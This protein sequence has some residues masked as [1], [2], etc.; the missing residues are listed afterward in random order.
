MTDEA[1]VFTDTARERKQMAIGSKHK[2]SGRVSHKVGLSQDHMSEAE[3]KKKNGEVKAYNMFVPWTWEEFKSAP[4]DICQ[5]YLDR[6]YECYHP[7]IAALSK[8][9]G[10][11]RETIRNQMRAKGVTLMC[12][13][14]HMYMDNAEAFEEFLSRVPVTE[15]YVPCKQPSKPALAPVEQKHDDAPDALASCADA[16]RKAFGLNDE[17]T[18]KE[19]PAIPSMK[20]CTFLFEGFYNEDYILKILNNSGLDNEKRYVIRIEVKEAE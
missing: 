7:N 20:R 15:E 10:K 2:K 11:S 3:L 9:L 12:K 6:L 14:G 13:P 4:A 5:T 1:Y 16:L 18:A 17:E 8:M 19:E